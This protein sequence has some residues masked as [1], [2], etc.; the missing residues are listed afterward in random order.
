MSGELL[1]ILN[2]GVQFDGFPAL[3]DVT[4]DLNP[5]E[6]VGLVGE[7]GSGKSTLARAILRLIPITSGQVVF[8]GENLAG[9]GGAALRRRRRDMQLVF[10]DPLASLNPRLRVAD[11]LSEPLQVHEPKL[12]ARDRQVRI[13]EMLARVGL[14][15]DVARRYPHEVSG[16]Q[17]QRI[18]IARAMILRPKLLVCDEPVSSLDTSIQGQIVNL[19]ADLQREFGTALLFISHN[20]A[21]VRHLSHRILV[22]YRGRL[23]ETADCGALFAAPAHPYTQALLAAVP[24]LNR[25]RPARAPLREE[26]A[27]RDEFSPGCAFHGRCVHGVASCRKSVPP[28][29]EVARGHFAACHRWREVVYS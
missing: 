23:V 11:A 29:E 8:C 3:E 19:L 22:I 4:F 1:R 13:A 25:E 6:T 7:S 28:P 20:L 27:G 17:C 18:G 5:G 9:L 12:P 2:L 16:G 14:P 24:S 21:V 26:P 10:Q 15:A